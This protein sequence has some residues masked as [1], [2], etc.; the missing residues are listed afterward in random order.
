[1]RK[2]FL[3]SPASTS[4][5]RAELL[6][7]SRA[8]FP[9][10]RTLH[11]GEGVA[12]GLVFSFLSGLYFRGKM[13]YA[14]RY[15]SLSPLIGTPE[16]YVITA[17]RGLIPAD[18]PISLADL[19]EF[20]SVPI[21]VRDQQYVAPLQRDIELLDDGLAEDDL[22]VLLGSVA[23][24]KYVDLLVPI[25]G[26]R[27]VFPVE[28][29]GLGDMSRGSVMLKSAASGLE[30]KYAPVIGAVRS[31][32]KGVSRARRAPENATGKSDEHIG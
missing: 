15:A 26:E 21:D 20:A 9:L 11:S 14:R 13:E 8:G 28:F 29:A 6:F 22:V 18:T 5:K 7:N 30:L 2:I 16:I 25:F 4:G 3:L 17:N 10:A 19:R 24:G 12:I 31:F 23:S 32:A 27:L 1:M